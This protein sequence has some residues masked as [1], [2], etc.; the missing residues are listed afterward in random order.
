MRIRENAGKSK[1]LAGG[2]YG[3]GG[4]THAPSVFG[5]TCDSS[6]SQAMPLLQLCSLRSH[7]AQAAWD[8][9][10]TAKRGWTRSFIIHQFCFVCYLWGNN[11][12]FYILGK[13]NVSVVRL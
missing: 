11:D 13:Q 2:N 1:R 5:S 6:F 10:P 3:G 7:N 4:F 8:E 9:P 12:S